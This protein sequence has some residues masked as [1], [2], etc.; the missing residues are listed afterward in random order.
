[1]EVTVVGT[2]EK[3]VM[4]EAGAK[5]VPEDVMLKGIIFAHQEIK[6]TVQFIEG[7]KAEIG[8]PKFEYQKAAAFPRSVRALRS[9][10][11]GSVLC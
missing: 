6:K 10:A 9:S 1:M 11:P 7:I 5:E 2:A 3:I 4:I 8:K